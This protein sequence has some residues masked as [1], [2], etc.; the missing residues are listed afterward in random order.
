MVLEVVLDFPAGYANYDES[1][2][3]VTPRTGAGHI[4]VSRDSDDPYY[5][6]VW[7]PRDGFTPTEEV[8]SR[9]PLLLIPGDACWTH[10]KKCTSGRVFALKFQSSDKREFFWMQKKNDAKDKNL[11]TLSADDKIIVDMFQ[12]YLTEDDQDEDEEDEDEDMIDADAQAKV[13]ESTNA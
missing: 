9:E 5:S 1:T 4:V 2:K 3:T 7:E 11:G 8:S 13:D 12:K 10:I 6:F